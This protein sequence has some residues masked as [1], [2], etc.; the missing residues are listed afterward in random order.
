MKG[1]NGDSDKLD[2]AERT[3]TP[4][5]KVEVREVYRDVALS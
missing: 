1:T 2:K 4:D 5:D 3:G